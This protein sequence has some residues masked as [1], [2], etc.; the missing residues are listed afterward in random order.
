[1]VEKGTPTFRH[2]LFFWL[3]CTGISSGSI[4]INGGKTMSCLPTMTGNGNHTTYKKTV[5]WKMVYNCL[6]GG[7]EHFLF[8]PS[9][10]NF[11]QSQLTFI[12]FRGF[13]TT[14]QFLWFPTAIFGKHMQLSRES[15]TFEPGPVGFLFPSS[16]PRGVSS[17]TARSKKTRIYVEL[18]D[19]KMFTVKPYIS[20]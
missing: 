20:G 1:M 8:S 15:A 2:T 10:G 6:V 3:Q 18:D 9:I 7:L 17:H 13:E 16:R 11:I 12:F 4:V 5:I 19:G 14:N